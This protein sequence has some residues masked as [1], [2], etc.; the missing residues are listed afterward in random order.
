MFK[1]K[2]LSYIMNISYFIPFFIPLQA[3]RSFM[4]DYKE[5]VDVFYE[6]SE[7]CL[8]NRVLC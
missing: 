1:N 5:H 4:D 7:F 2:I 8:E 3:I 6:V